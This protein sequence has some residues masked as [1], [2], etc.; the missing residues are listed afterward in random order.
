MVSSESTKAWSGRR[1]VL[2][3]LALVA[4]VVAPRVWAAARAVAPARDAFRY[5]SASTC[6]QQYPLAVAAG[7]IDCQP[8]YPL[9]LAWIP[10]TG[11][12]ADAATGWRTSQAWSV[13]C[14]TWFILAA[15]AAGSRIFGAPV[16]W[17]GCVF[18]SV[19]PR[20]IRYSVDVLSDNLHAAL[21][22]TAFALLA[23]SWPA[24]RRWGLV[25]AAAAG[26]ATGLAWWTRFEAILLPAAFATAMLARQ[27]LAADRL[28]WGRWLLRTGAYLAPI[29]LAIVAYAELR[30][31]LFSQATVASIVESRGRIE[32]TTAAPDALSRTSET[33]FAA[34]L[35]P[36]RTPIDAWA[37]SAGG[38][39]SVRAVAGSVGR[40]LWE[41]LQ[42]TRVWVGVLCV[43]GIVAAA[44]RR[45]NAG[46]PVVLAIFALALCLAMA[47]LVRWKAGFLAGR[48][49]T[50]AIPLAGMFAA[51]AVVDVWRRLDERGRAERAGAAPEGG[52]ATTAA[53]WSGLRPAT[54]WVAAVCVA[55]VSANAPG[56]M[57]RLHE[58]RQGHVAAARW[59]REHSA[60]GESVFDPSWVCGYFAG[61]PLWHPL[62]GATP[63]FRYA[64]IEPSIAARPPVHLAESIDYVRRHGRIAAEF[65]ARPGARR[66]G[67]RVV[68]L[69][70]AEAVA[71]TR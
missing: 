35:A 52:R 7:W 30:G 24:R 48:Y 67:V 50:P 10:G 29:A 68:E 49:M 11:F 34:F 6:L 4:I 27:V 41:F 12:S 13:A 38:A 19:L 44:V 55:A 43:A 60:E 47:A 3:A 69:P 32:R 65:P 62:P 71:G 40:A 51:A 21:W 42:E 22:M 15:F 28:S 37:S 1:C 54:A 46:N 31:G 63:N 33:E 58:D 23:W 17:L 53:R 5:W 56:W 14:S 39:W 64:V 57:V 61:R 9:T 59:I 26:I 16:A 20:Q 70:A 2:A 45:R 8:L 25:A 18:A 66:I 36:P